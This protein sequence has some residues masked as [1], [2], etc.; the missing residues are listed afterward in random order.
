MFWGCFNFHCVGSLY[1]VTWMMNAKKYS[2]VV[3]QKV[4][5]EMEWTLIAGKGVFQQDLTP[6]HSAKKVK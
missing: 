4:V 1:P 3:R 5:T 6:C 2:E